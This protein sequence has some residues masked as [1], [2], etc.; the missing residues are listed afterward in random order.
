MRDA[1]RAVV[2][3]GSCAV[4]LGAV[5]ALAITR[6]SAHATATIEKSSF[7]PSIDQVRYRFTITETA[8]SS[9]PLAT[10]PELEQ[11]VA[12]PGAAPFESGELAELYLRRA[13]TAGDPADYARAEAMARRSLAAMP[14]PN[15]APLTLARIATARHE[16]RAAIALARDYLR[17]SDSAGA[18]TVLTTSYL[19]L[20]EL[21][22]AAETAEIQVSEKPSSGAYL[23]R[24]LVYQAQGRDAEAA[25]DFS[26]AAVVEDFGDIKEAAR[27]RTL[28]GRFLLRRGDAT[29]AQML[30]TEALRLV[31]DDPLALGQRA[32]LALRTGHAR[33][34]RAEFER[35]FVGS[36]LV[37][38]LMD[39][40]RAQE[41]SGDPTAATS[42]RTQV[43]KLIR[44]ELASSGTGHAL[45]LVEI[46]VDRATPADLAE[47][48]TVGTAEITRRPSCASS[49]HA[50]IT[51]RSN[52]AKVSCRSAPRSPPVLATRASTSSHRVSRLRSATR[53]ARTCIARKQTRSI[54]RTAAGAISV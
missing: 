40:A 33:E 54:P 3:V 31:P 32:E 11:R 43:E 53:R 21:P 34:A 1:K 8:P 15:G 5:A 36:R 51:A 37:R 14:A 48:I 4:A 19:A 9:D 41:L 35:A 52:H 22:A 47:A 27:L 44:A 30:F 46:L 29:G 45:D 10:I 50:P 6:D 23:M 18:Y 12:A 49:S 17:S 25:Y 20:G 38:Y 2:V 7:T 42:T 39:E 28:W 16:F 26:R 13:T 24:A